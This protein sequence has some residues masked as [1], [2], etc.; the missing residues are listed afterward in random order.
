MTGLILFVFFSINLVINGGQGLGR[1]NLG[2]AL[3][4]SVD[5]DV[6]C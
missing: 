6:G 2:M 4:K 1:W 3:P 5:M